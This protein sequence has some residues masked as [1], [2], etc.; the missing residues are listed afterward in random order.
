LGELAGGR[1]LRIDE[2]PKWQAAVDAGNA[3]DGVD[4]AGWEWFRRRLKVGKDEQTGAPLYFQYE[5]NADT[6]SA[7]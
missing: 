6:P 3:P 2:A 1:V 5:V 7:E 4:A